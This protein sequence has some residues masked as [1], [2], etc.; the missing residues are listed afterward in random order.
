MYKGTNTILTVWKHCTYFKHGHVDTG[1]PQKVISTNE[2][3]VKGT[4]VFGKGRVFWSLSWRGHLWSLRLLSLVQCYKCSHSLRR[5][6]IYFLINSPSEQT[7][8][9]I[10]KNMNYFL[11]TGHKTYRVYLQDSTPRSDMYKEWNNYLINCRL[12]PLQWTLPT[13]VKSRSTVSLSCFI[14]F[15]CQL[16]GN[17][18]IG[19][20]FLFFHKKGI[21]CWTVCVLWTKFDSTSVGTLTFRNLASHI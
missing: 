21:M 18:L 2:R 19:N 20:M 6:R 7:Q 14:S 16:N 5:V 15:G 1:L 17:S 3:Y 10:F 9:I 8:N 12:L 11:W 4:N 13:S